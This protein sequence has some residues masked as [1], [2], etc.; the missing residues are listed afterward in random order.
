MEKKRMPVR[1]GLLL[2]LWLKPVFLGLLTAFLA[3]F[4]LFFFEG[5]YI[6]FRILPPFSFYLDLLYFFT[7]AAFVFAVAFNALYF[8]SR[9]LHLPFTLLGNFWNLTAPGV[10]IFLLA[11]QPII[12][13]AMKVL[14]GGEVVSIQSI[15]LSVAALISLSFL[16]IFPYFRG[17][18]ATFLVIAAA[19]AR[20]LILPFENHFFDDAIALVLYLILIY[21]L[22]FFTFT[23]LQIRYRQ[24]LTPDYAFYEVPFRLQFFFFAIAVLSAA[25]I[26]VVGKMIFLPA[27][28]FL[29]AIFW[30]LTVFS[31]DTLK[32]R[33]EKLPGPLVIIVMF[34]VPAGLFCFA[35]VRL[36]SYPPGSGFFNVV[37]REGKVSR[38]ILYLTGGLLDRDSDGNSA[39]PGGDPDDS[40]SS[41]RL[42][43]IQGAG[44]ELSCRGGPASSVITIVTLAGIRPL[45][46]GRPLGGLVLLKPSV[47]TGPALRGFFRGL[48]GR[49]LE[50]E[51][52][53]PP[54]FEDYIRMGYRTICGGNDA[55]EKYL[56]HDSPLKLDAG[57][58][59]IVKNETTSPSLEELAANV[60][61]NFSFY[62][63]ARTLVWIHYDAKKHARRGILE[64]LFG[65]GEQNSENTY[66][67]IY[68][69]LAPF[70]R[71]DLIVL[72]LGGDGD[73]R[74]VMNRKFNAPAF[75]G[76]A[77][78]GIFKRVTGF[79]DS[80]IR[81][82]EGTSFAEGS[83][84]WMHAL[85]EGS[86]GIKPSILYVLRDGRITA[87]DGLSGSISTLD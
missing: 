53:N 47:H 65:V 21:L 29:S 71:G 1:T 59:I 58:Q 56:S 54:F 12:R 10:I 46:G 51:K 45:E 64:N 22:T 42:Q 81:D 87:F 48:D 77:F 66:L 70:A 86:R 43:P 80:P 55:G 15:I 17:I 79:D 6:F 31:F 63:E 83:G 84:T 39:W 72:S 5:F 3:F 40:D 67:D 44:S 37:S 11:G 16:Y 4:A 74:A 62:S 82:E 41:R 85:R 68:P 13:E 25:M 52:E 2:R 20:L 50:L 7:A 27:I 18:N 30:L 34:L 19:S 75:Y 78:P 24:H 32:N 23:A 14:E 61:R 35:S 69:A 33:S 76:S 60:Q 38:E 9:L 49:Q 26:T 36:S 8:L 73:V 57:C 28:I